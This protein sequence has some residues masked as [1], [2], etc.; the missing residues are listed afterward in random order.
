[1]TSESNQ[2]DAS[3]DS[4]T[5]AIVAEIHLAPD[6]TPPVNWH[7][8]VRLD[9][10]RALLE[11]AVERLSHESF[12]AIVLLGDLSNAADAESLRTVRD[13][14]LSLDR[15]V[16]A[17]P[18]N[19][20][21]D[22]HPDARHRFRTHLKNEQMF[23]SPSAVSLPDAP[24]AVLVEIQRDPEDDRLTS[25]AYTLPQSSPEDLPILFSHFPLLPLNDLLADANLKH[26]GDL[27]DL[28]RITAELQRSP[29]PMLVVH[30]HLHVRAARAAGPVL[31]LS[32]AALVEAPHEVTLLTISRSDEA[33]ITVR[34]RAIAVAPHQVERLPVL[35]PP[36]ETWRFDENGW[37]RLAP[38]SDTSAPA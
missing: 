2:R 27:R 12:D 17:V 28:D 19:H 32:C 1:M 34:R 6:G 38:K 15:P 8:D 11:R 16:L 30:G 14:A 29:W 13:L 33:P 31:Q 18:G 25:S 7:N 36:E 9:I 21:I 37:T 35:G 23:L 22:R 20:D 5:F 4:I 3:G 10:S 24:T 26:A